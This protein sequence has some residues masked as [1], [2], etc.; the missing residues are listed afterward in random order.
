M[1]LQE[2]SAWGKERDAQ[3]D[4]NSE[5]NLISN[6]LISSYLLQPEVLFPECVLKYKFNLKP[7]YITSPNLPL[8]AYT[9]RLNIPGKFQKNIVGPF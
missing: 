9:L 1:K 5:A 8:L 7:K 2:E 4:F 3:A 6:I